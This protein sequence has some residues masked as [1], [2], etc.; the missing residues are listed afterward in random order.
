MFVPKEHDRPGFHTDLKISRLLGLLRGYLSESSD[1][2]VL[3]TKKRHCVPFVMQPLTTDNQWEIN[4]HSPRQS[5]KLTGV[6]D[7]MK[8]PLRQLVKMPLSRYRT[9]PQR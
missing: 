1:G 5:E 3:W 6:V 4:Q 7:D 8:W 9:G 2:L